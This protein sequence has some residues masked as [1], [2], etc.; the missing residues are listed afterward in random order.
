[1]SEKRTAAH[2]L[3]PDPVVGALVSD[4]SQGPPDTAVLQGF[5]GESTEPGTWRLYLTATLDEYVEV[6]PSDIL[7]SETRA[8]GS[9]TVVW[10]PRS[11]ALRHV[12]T[13]SQD[14]QADLLG[15][16]IAARHLP[17]VPAPGVPQGIP[18]NHHTM[19]FTCP[20]T[21]APVCPS[22]IQGACPS[23]FAHVCGPVVTA[24]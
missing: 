4:P 18:P 20:T 17:L 3:K 22:N 8:D 11:L 9:G 6:A 5:L 10:V 24:Q 14:V 23:G 2:E 16:A 12:G 19:M 7:H 21:T 15:G 1:M 13:K